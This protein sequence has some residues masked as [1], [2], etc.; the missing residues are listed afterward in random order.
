[1]QQVLIMADINSD[2]EITF[3]FRVQE[4]DKRDRSTTNV[5]INAAVDNVDQ[6]QLP[7]QS[8]DSARLSTRS[9]NRPSRSSG[10]DR[11]S[12]LDSYSE[13]EREDIHPSRSKNSTDRRHFQS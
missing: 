11:D 8:Q 12:S 3:N 10:T 13:S 6:D 9:L 7:N 5:N 4:G 1:M 2:P